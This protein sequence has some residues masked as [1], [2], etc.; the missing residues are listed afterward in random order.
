[1]SQGEQL[2]EGQMWVVLSIARCIFS[3]TGIT[4]C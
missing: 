3:D 1:M 2:E 4:H